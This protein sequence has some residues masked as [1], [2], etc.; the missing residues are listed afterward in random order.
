MY[1]ER[2]RLQWL[3][4]E[5][6][7]SEYGCLRDEVLAALD[8][9]LDCGLLAH[10]CARA[11]CTKCQHSRL[12]AFSC[13]KRGLCPSCG[14]KRAI[15]FAEHLAGSVLKSVP[16]RHVVFSIPKRLRLF[17]KYSRKHAA[18]LFEAAWGTLLELFH[19]VL[20]DMR[21]GAVLTLQTAGANLNFNP[22]L[23]GIVTDGA[24][25]ESGI[26]HQLASFPAE[27]ATELFTH[28][29][30]KAMRRENLI[31]DSVI[32]S[33]LSWRHSGFSVWAGLPFQPG[34]TDSQLFVAR[35][36]DRAPVANSHIEIV[37]DIVSYVTEDKTYDFDA[38][39]FLARI[40]PHI[41]DKW[42]STTR[43][44]GVYSSRSRGEAPKRA[45]HSPDSDNITV[46]PHTDKRS[47]SSTWAA[48]IKK[49]YET[50]PLICEKCGSPMK[51]KA[52]ITD[53]REAARIAN[54]LGLAFNA[55]PPITGP[56]ESVAA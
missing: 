47:A 15:L 10:G 3:W 6:F 21:P 19:A 1:H 46:L 5:R 22:H 31:D 16:H 37:D 7:Q 12:I 4:E 11:C 2:E 26:F 52:F 42:E 24:C 28:K 39:S 14:A 33:I 51:I 17:F 40:T 55:P 9:Y 27:R 30:L 36:I 25:D 50:D 29:L 13:K 35:Y 20:P 44:Y 49:V 48:L 43:Y 34:D 38:L 32:E 8:A 54:S 18:L 23:H 56:P 53:P 41:P 45:A